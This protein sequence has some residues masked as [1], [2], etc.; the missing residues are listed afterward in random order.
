MVLPSS[1]KYSI[2]HPGYSKIKCVAK[3]IA[4]LI[5]LGSHDDLWGCCHLE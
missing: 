2:L 3:S 5:F 1:D 4:R